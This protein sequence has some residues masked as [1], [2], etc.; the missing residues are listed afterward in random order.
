MLFAVTIAFCA[1]LAQFGVVSKGV[2]VEVKRSAKAEW[3]SASR[4]LIIGVNNYGG[5]F[6]PLRFAVNDAKE[7]G[8]VLED[9]YGFAPQNVTYLLDDKATPTAIRRAIARLADP[10]N[11]S[12]NDQILIYF[13]G[14]GHTVRTDDGKEFT[15]L[16]PFGLQAEKGDLNNPSIFLSEAISVRDIWGWLAPCRAKHVLLIADACFSGALTESRSA[17]VVS[18]G[19][20]GQYLRRPARQIITA[21]TADQQS[22]EM[23]EL[24]HGVFTS[25]LLEELEAQAASPGYVFSARDLHSRLAKTVGNATRGKQTPLFRDM[26]TSGEVMFMALSEPGERSRPKTIAPSKE[27]RPATA[28][29]RSKVVQIAVR[30]VGV[31]KYQWGGN[32]INKA[33]DNSHFVSQVFRMAGITKGMQPPVHNQETAGT[34][35]YVAK[36]K[37]ERGG[38]VLT[39]LQSRDLTDLRPGDRLIFHQK[40]DL[41]YSQVGSHHTGIYIGS[42]G[43]IKHA[44][45]HCSSARGTVAIDDLNGT[46]MRT[47]QYALRDQ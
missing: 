7:V 22:V 11:V 1:T 3:Y 21:G 34:L 10:K 18:E 25:K 24:G 41:N 6:H 45:V 17:E 13:S 33:I 23:S 46:Y 39:A 37:I 9:C 35:V 38:K 5:A 8:R 44:F 4:A 19:V 2:E 30:Y 32:D 15:F 20:I 31:P 12:V 29:G 28:M 16:V 26:D 43:P 36:P 42:Y 14:H 40:L 47:L 27:S